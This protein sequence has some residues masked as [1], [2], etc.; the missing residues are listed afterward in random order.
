MPNMAHKES[1]SKLHGWLRLIKNASLSSWELLR[2]LKAAGM[3]RL[4]KKPAL[5]TDD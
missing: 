4:L 3:K 2:Y 5:D 1:R